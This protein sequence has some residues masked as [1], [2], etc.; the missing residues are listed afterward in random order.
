M[1]PKD[2][3]LQ[4]DAVDK[5]FGDVVALDNFSLDIGAGE[6]FVLLGPSGCGKS[7]ALQLAN[8]LL[9][10]DS[11]SIIVGGESITEVDPVQ[12]RRGIGYVIQ[13]IGLFPHR[14]VAANVG[15]VCRLLGWS[16][17]DTQSRVETLMDLV[18]LPFADYGSRYPSEL[19][20]GQQ[21]RVGVARA[22]AVD[23]PLL[24]MDEPFAALDPE[25]RRNLQVEFRSWVE[26]LGTTVLFVSHDVDEALILGDR[27]GVMATAGHLAQVGTPLEVLT[28]P[29]D[30]QV[31]AFLGPDRALKRLSVT[32]IDVQGLAPCS[33]P[34]APRIRPEDSLQTAMLS[35]LT[36][37]VPAIAVA[38]A[39]DE[40]LGELT[41]ADVGKQ[42]RLAHAA[43]ETWS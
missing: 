21:Q 27:L 31:R 17:T 41:M 16:R 13:Q 7:T 10:P 3:Y 36:N 2:A 9:D 15:T 1:H 14:T 6:I 33:D 22:L 32:P 19:S 23:P 35:L 25:I 18:G 4:F 29:V 24:L 38:A 28:A 30:D 20:G 43:F 11:G 39:G 37:D 40:P 12:L 42:A 26:R 5:K 34:S 8:R